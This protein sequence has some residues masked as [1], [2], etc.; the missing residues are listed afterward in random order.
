MRPSGPGRTDGTVPGNF[1]Y[2][3]GRLHCEG[4]ALEAL[5]AEHGTPLYAYSRR[6]IVERVRRLDAAFE[7][8]DRLIAYSVKAN[9]NL[10]VLRL[11]GR[12]GCGADIVSGGE[13]YRALK[14]GIPADRIVFS[15]VGKTAAE[16]DAGLAAGILCFNVESEG[17]L[18]L[19][20]ER[21]RAAGQAAPVA[22][23]INPDIESPTPHAYTR[24][25]HRATKFGIATEEAPGLY[26]VAADLDGVEPVGID[27]HIGSQILE[28]EPYRESLLHLLEV[29]DDLRGEGIA[30]R[31]LDLGGGFGVAYDAES[32]PAPELFAERI[33]PYL[34]ASGLRLILE[35][36]RYV[37]G[38]AGVLL[39]RVLYV[40]RTGSKIFV[41][42]DA[43]MNDLLRPSHYSSYHRVEPA[44]RVEGRET[45]RLDVVGP[46]CESGDF[47]ALDR[48]MPLP[49]PGELLAIHTT[50]AYGFSMASTYNARPRPAEVLVEGDGAR[51]I[52][53]RENHDDLVRG[54]EDLLIE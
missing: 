4:V 53:R 28:P 15:G 10:S 38:H 22:L 18:R 11:L 48:D 14:A 36:G 6:S 9:G 21:G 50:G 13:L 3:D 43:G 42:T 31:M 47:L 41:I 30:L 12:E 40:K 49:E 2:R 19:L 35:P 23:R 16:L 54:E 39:T 33:V 5:A 17:E 51:L 24:T 45:R 37:I 27:A 25:G 29:V 34:A 26:R 32:D 7:P 46:I 44:R 20:A 1:G 8:L 52:R